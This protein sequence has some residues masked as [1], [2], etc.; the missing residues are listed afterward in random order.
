MSG[1]RTARTTYSK[2]G[3][4]TITLDLLDALELSEVLDYLRDWLTAASD[5]VRADLHRFGCDDNATTT[6][7]RRLSAFTELIVTGQADDD[8]IYPGQEQDHHTPGSLNYQLDHQG[9]HDGDQ[10]HPW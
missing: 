2:T 6:V 7:C 10:D 9:N 3:N 1:M 8:D 5:H 4:G